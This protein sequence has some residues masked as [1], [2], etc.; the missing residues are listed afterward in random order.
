MIG[1]NLSAGNATG[2]N[3]QP[4]HAASVT[5][6]YAQ[7]PPQHDPNKGIRTAGTIAIWVW[8]L[9]ALIPILLIGVCF[10]CCGGVGA[11]GF[12]LPDPTP[13]SSF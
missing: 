6:P 11:L 2:G 13:S 5:Y 9:I 12:L 3:G 4:W 8:I 10:A 1:L 7:Q